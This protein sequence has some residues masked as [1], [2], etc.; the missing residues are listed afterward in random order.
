MKNSR[1]VMAPVT[2]LLGLWLSASLAFGD[3]I[4]V[5]IEKAVRLSGIAGQIE[6]AG[7]SILSTVPSDVFPDQKARNEAE[8]YVRKNAS[9]E[10]MSD[11]VRSSIRE[12]YDKDKMESVIR[13]YDSPLGKKV[14][15]LQDNALDAGL[16]KSIREGRK[17]VATLDETRLKTIKRIIDAENVSESNDILVTTLVRGL[18]A[19]SSEET[20]D[21]E[22]E[23]ETISSKLKAAEKTLANEQHRMGDMALTAYALTFRSLSDKELEELAAFHESA[24]A[25]WFRDVTL[26][27]LDRAI[28]SVSKA[29]GAALTASRNTGRSEQ[30]QGTSG[31]SGKRKNAGDD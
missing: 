14:G 8:T 17:T 30:D 18:L 11:M 27:G 31:T 3:E 1:L 16:L 7:K 4:D 25:M 24:D 23:A 28:F 22:N 26:N 2:V 15:R 9:K 13:F 12:R 10:A 20:K 29:L 19:G 6:A 5:S 21:S